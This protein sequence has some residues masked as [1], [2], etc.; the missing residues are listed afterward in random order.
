MG[1]VPR[2]IQKR[3]PADALQPGEAL[4][5]ASWFERPS[6]NKQLAGALLLGRIPTKATS[7][8]REGAGGGSCADRLPGGKVVVALSDRRLLIFGPT[9]GRK[10]PVPLA[11]TY[12]PEEVVDIRYKMGIST[13]SFRLAFSDGSEAVF[14]VPSDHNGKDLTKA[15][16]SFCRGAV[17]S[18]PAP[19][20]PPPPP[21]G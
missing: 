3:I 8:S 11:V 4:V 9:G 21:A 7:T 16:A 14:D 10:D 18:M 1:K 20:P 17:G 2:D 19:A 13:S 5:S 15:G 6:A 12:A